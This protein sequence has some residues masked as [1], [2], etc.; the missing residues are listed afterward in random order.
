MNRV[1]ALERPK[2]PLV[3]LPR[4]PRAPGA[5]EVRL[6]VEACALGQVDW[7]LVTLD[8]PPR[9]PLVPGVEAVGVVDAVGGGVSLALGSRVLVT[10]LASSCGTCAACHAGEARWCPAARFLG[11]DLD[12][13]LG[14]HVTLPVRHLVPAPPVAVAQAACLG[15]SAWTALAAVRATGLA[16][17]AR[18]GVL[19]VGGVGH[20][21][22]QVAKARG[23]SV[24]A[25]DVDSHRRALGV[26]LGAHPWPGAASLD[27]VV[28]GTP[29][30]QAL[31]R[32]LKSVRAGGVV[33]AVGT[34][35][36]GRVD[37]PLAD[38]VARG[39]RVVGSALGT[40]DD[41]AA[42][43][44]LAQ[45]GALVPHVEVVPLDAAVSRLWQLRDGGF[46]GRLVFTP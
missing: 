13:A 38:V 14:T 35:P 37:L 28:V 19:G 39:V 16:S 20:L 21:V 15:G 18:L 32:A 42:A 25:D 4:E 41:L 5:G 24:F 9:L 45:Q 8:A 33:V 23:L 2:E 26:S 6:R 22:L 1:L 36:T 3:V 44:A 30:A 10:P 46:V 7:N 43:L 17:G 40:H 12:G 34:S 27:A 29:S 31:Q 11:R